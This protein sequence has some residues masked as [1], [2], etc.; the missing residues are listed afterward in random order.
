[1]PKPRFLSSCLAPARSVVGILAAL[2]LS[3]C[4]SPQQMREGVE[5]R[6]DW[7]ARA[8]D[9]VDRM[10]YSALIE[11][12]PLDRDWL[13]LRFNGGRNLALRVREPCVAQVREASRLQLITS[14]PNTLN[15]SADRVQ[16]DGWTCFIDEMRPVA[17]PDPLADA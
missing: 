17:N 15:R 12:Y 14:I 2:L 7:T 10:T 13:M 3:A 6:Q 5:E 1:M 9:P 11:W 16:L 8:G 4:L